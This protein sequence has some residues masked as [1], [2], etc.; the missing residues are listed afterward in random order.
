MK[1]RIAILFLLGISFQSF[2]QDKKLSK[3]ELLYNQE[4]YDIAVRYSQ[5]LIDKKGYSE[6]PIPYLF[7]ALSLTRMS[8]EKWFIPKKYRPSGSNI[9]EALKTFKAL[10]EKAFYTRKYSKYINTTHK[11]IKE[12][13]PTEESSFSVVHKKKKSKDKKK[14]DKKP[15]IS[16]GK[17]DVVVQY[18][19]TFLGVP[20]KYG[21]TNDKGFDCSGFSGHVLKEAGVDIPRT[22]RDQATFSKKISL[23][24]AKKG[25]LLFFGKSNSSIHHVGVVISEMNEPL[26]MIHSSTSSGIMITTIDNSDY[27]KRVLQYA[28]R[29][30]ND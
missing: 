13:N 5:K 1:L 6:N 17:R 7:K 8:E 25:D 10:D 14:S 2:A 19:K 4:N 26:T 16:S 27:W 23:K 21:G 9:A 22:S 3:L 29:V 12:V 20:Y 28:G 18:S 30:I 15:S 11:T 24:E